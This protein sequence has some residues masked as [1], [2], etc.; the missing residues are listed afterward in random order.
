MKANL[1]NQIE[2]LNVKIKKLNER[3]TKLNENLESLAFKIFE[4]KENID[5][6]KRI[7]TQKKIIE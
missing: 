7:L 4:N 3:I 1:E 6:M 5:I 2:S